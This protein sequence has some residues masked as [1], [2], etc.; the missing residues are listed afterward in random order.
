MVRQGCGAADGRGSGEQR[1][2]E[3]RAGEER[4]GT[5]LAGAERARA[6]RVGDGD[7]AGPLPPPDRRAL[8]VPVGL[9]CTDLAIER[10]LLGWLGRLPDYR[11]VRATRP[12]ELVADAAAGRLRLV[13]LGGEFPPARREGYDALRRAGL[14]LVVLGTEPR[15]ADWPGA[16]LL[17]ETADFPALLAALEAALRDEEPPGDGVSATAVHAPR[18]RQGAGRSTPGRRATAGERDR[19]RAENASS[20]AGAR[21][22]AA[23]QTEA[24]QKEGAGDESDVGAPA[25]TSPPRASDEALVVAVASGLGSHGRT[26]LACGLARALGA[27]AP[28]ILVEADIAGPTLAARLGRHPIRNLYMLA[29]RGPSTGDDWA[30]ALSREVQFLDDGAARGAHLL[31]GFQR[32]TMRGGVGLPFLREALE[33]LRARYRFVILDVGADLLGDELHRGAAQLA[34]AVLLVG[35]PSLSGEGRWL[36][37]WKTLTGVG[38]GVPPGRIHLV[39]NGW[40]RRVHDGWAEIE[41]TQHATTGRPLAAVIPWSHRE[42]ARAEREQRPLGAR[43]GPAARATARLAEQIAGRSIS[44]AEIADPPRA[45]RWWRGGATPPVVVRP[46]SEDGGEAG[47]EAGR[48]V[49]PAGWGAPPPGGRW[50]LAFARLR[51]GAR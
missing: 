5:A 6:E 44:P 36:D 10:R 3:E 11:L 41:A 34:D 17:P 50:R 20:P 12:A 24:W 37:G 49:W 48:G 21:R 15:R 31:C 32:G 45:R 19:A 35:T 16:H 22:V 14:G 1:A 18:S 25:S 23:W 4:P 8:A 28:T 39:L 27:A 2:R 46:G 38:V 13:I 47:G 51:R 7:G 9:V 29:Q 40:D 33:Q 43:R 42:V 30:A 26:T